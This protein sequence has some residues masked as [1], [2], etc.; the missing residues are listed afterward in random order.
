MSFFKNWKTTLA[1]V[2]AVIGTI[3]HC[4]SAG[5]VTSIDIAAFTAGVGMIFAKDHNVTGGDVR[6]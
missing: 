2:A 6:Q 5:T 4:V 1:G 3:S